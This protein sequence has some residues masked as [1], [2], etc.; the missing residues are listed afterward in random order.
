MKDYIK[1]SIESRI[2]RSLETFPIVLITGARQT[3]KTTL[4]RNLQTEKQYRYVTLDNPVERDLAKNDPGLFLKKYMPPLIIDEIQ[5]ATELLP[6]IKIAVDEKT[7]NDDGNSNGMYILTGSQI[8]KMM[9]GVSE[10]LAGRVSVLTLHGLSTNERFG[11]DDAQFVPVAGH[12]AAREQ[13]RKMGLAELYELIFRGQ[14]P[15]LAKD[16]KLDT[17][18]YYSGYLQTYLERDIRDLIAVRN[19]AKF[20]KFMSSIA[21][22]SGQE[23]VYDDLAKEMEIDIKTAQSWMSVLKTSGLVY[24]LQPYSNNAIKRIVKRPKLYF[25]DTG[26]ACF[27]SKYVDSQTLEISAYSGSIFETYVVSEIIKTYVNNGKYPEMYLYYYRDNNRK[28]IDLLIL[29]NG[30]VYPIEIKKSANPSK[31]IV[32]NFGVL[33]PLEKAGLK[34]GEGGIICMMDRVV[35]IDEK[36]SFIPIQCI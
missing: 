6:Y 7:V 17:H 21:V 29:Q 22:R 8:F 20:L 24:F 30:T 35:P 14:F 12:L 25:M 5:Y 26:L 11:E 18:E 13:K 3:G 4:L 33:A 23:L 32:K 9:K 15:R 36:N 31:T 2:L 16:A 1:R 19:E 27:L 10:S 34:I 28:E